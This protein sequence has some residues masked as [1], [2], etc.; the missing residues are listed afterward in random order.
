MEAFKQQL[1]SKGNSK[2]TVLSHLRTVLRFKEWLEGENL[3]EDQ[4][5]YNDVLGY[6]Q[7][8]QKEASSK[9]R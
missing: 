5:R 1:L 3:E 2:K 7:Y 6:V 9:K 4:V 8:L